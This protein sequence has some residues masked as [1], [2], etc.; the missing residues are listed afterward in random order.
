ML[1]IFKKLTKLS[2]LDLSATEITP[3]SLKSMGQSIN[4]LETLVVKLNHGLAGDIG[5]SWV[6]KSNTRLN[7]LDVS[8]LFKMKDASFS[9]LNSEGCPRF[10]SLQTLRMDNAAELSE[11]SL[12]WISKQF[13]ELT[14]L[15]VIAF[16][17]VVTPTLLE[18]ANNNTNLTKLCLH[19]TEGVSG[20][21]MQAIFS[22]CTKLTCAF[23]KIF[24]TPQNVCPKL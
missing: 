7:T 9:F 6:I 18:F 17:G 11:V 4:S 24:W 13:P 3:A 12:R 5:L 19:G 10:T 16:P 1:P 8:N 20:E 14:S 22:K 15:S 21:G 2:C 23:D